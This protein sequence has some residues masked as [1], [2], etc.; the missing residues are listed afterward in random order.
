MGLLPVPSPFK[1]QETGRRAVSP[2]LATR[3]RPYREEAK[4]KRI[5]YAGL[6][7]W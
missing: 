1:G 4:N 5:R 7:R 6:T 2:M 3:W